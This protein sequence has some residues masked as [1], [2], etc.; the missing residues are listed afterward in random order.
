MSVRIAIYGA[1]I[2]SDEYQAAVKL[3]PIISKSLRLEV[4][5]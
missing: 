3:K 4:V 1:D 5:G 2:E